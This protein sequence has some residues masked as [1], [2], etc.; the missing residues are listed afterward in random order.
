MMLRAR[1]HSYER[2][3]TSKG[4]LL[5]EGNQGKCPEE[6][7]YCFRFLSRILPF[8]PDAGPNDIEPKRHQRNQ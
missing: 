1:H 2:S 4:D 7:V 6:I 3:E 8:T 5:K